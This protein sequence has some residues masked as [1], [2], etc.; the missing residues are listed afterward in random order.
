MPILDTDILIDYL[1]KKPEAIK[2]IANLEKLKTSLRTTVFNVG[3]LY[4]GAFLS[5]NV[6]KSL[7]GIQ[8]LLRKLEIIYFEF[9]DAQTYGQISAELRKAGEPSGDF[10]ELIAS[11]VI[12]RNETLIT[13]NIRHYDKIPRISLQ[14]WE[15][16]PNES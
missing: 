1:R 6:P 12:T 10:D 13:R 9:E 11:I 15:S 4:K 5:S 16:I 7:R 14:N 2:T 3:E 8:T